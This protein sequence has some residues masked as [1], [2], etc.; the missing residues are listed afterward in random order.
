MAIINFYGQPQFVC[1]CHRAKEKLAIGP[2]FPFRLKEKYK[3][4]I[5]GMQS[6]LII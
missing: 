6:F 3:K 4:Q 2:S 5:P 1:K